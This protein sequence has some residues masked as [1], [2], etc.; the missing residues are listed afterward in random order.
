MDSLPE[1]SLPKL[2]LNLTEQLEPVVT[3]LRDPKMCSYEKVLSYS[4]KSINVLSL[5]KSE[6]LTQL[7]FRA[8]TNL[9]PQY[10]ANDHLRECAERLFQHLLSF[11]C[12]ELKRFV[13]RN[14][15]IL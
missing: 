12:T 10:N 13:K 7:I 5:V 14:W 3:L 9:T 11:E 2:L 4:L 15:K 8:I 1:K 6:D